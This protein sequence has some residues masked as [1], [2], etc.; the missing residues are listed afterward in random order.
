MAASR[1][2]CLISLLALLTPTQ[3]A[4]R[5]RVQSVT[6]AGVAYHQSAE[7]W[8][9]LRSGDALRL[10]HESDNAQDPWAV[11]VDWQGYTLGYLPREQSAPVA[12]ALDRGM[13]LVARIARLREHPNPR[14]RILIEVF[15]EISAPS[16]APR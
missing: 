6:L 10:V 2:L 9:Q 15:A 14:E 11:R 16:P 8:A 4:T 3:A 13:L 7:V 12:Q 1:V 5:V